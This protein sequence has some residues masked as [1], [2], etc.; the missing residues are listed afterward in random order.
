MIMVPR[1]SLVPLFLVTSPQVLLAETGGEGI[2]RKDS[3]CQ[4]VYPGWGGGIQR[5]LT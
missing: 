3:K 2:S 4:S 5:G 1:D